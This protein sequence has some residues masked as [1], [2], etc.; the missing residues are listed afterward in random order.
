M[1]DGRKFSKI[2]GLK[3]LLVED[4]DQLARSL[5]EKLLAYATG[6]EPAKLDKPHLDTIVKNVSAR[7]HGFRSLIHEVVESDVFQTK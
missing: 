3:A 2:D 4:K 6:A 1:D 5:A 7:N